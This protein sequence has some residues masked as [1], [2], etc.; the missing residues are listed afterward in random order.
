MCV[1][2]KEDIAQQPSAQSAAVA[3]GAFVDRRRCA[4]NHTTTQRERVHS[5]NTYTQHTKEFKINDR[6][7]SMRAFKSTQEA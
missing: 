3:F 2:G 4:G 5:K 7:F 1:G 6:P